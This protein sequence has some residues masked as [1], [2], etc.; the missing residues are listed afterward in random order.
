MTSPLKRSLAVLGVIAL[1]AAGIALTGLPA[2]A[3]P[4]SATIAAPDCAVPAAATVSISVSNAADDAT[5]LTYKIVQD[6]GTVLFDN[7]TLAPGE[8]DDYVI[9]VT[10]DVSTPLQVIDVTGGVIAGAVQTA[11]C[12]PNFSPTAT[13]TIGEA[14]CVLPSGGI[15]PPS[16]GFLWTFDNSSGVGAADYEFVKNDTVVESGTLAAGE[17]RSYAAS[18]TPNESGTSAIR[19]VDAAGDP[20]VVATGSFD[21]DCEPGPAPTGAVTDAS[22]EIPTGGVL[23]PTIPGVEYTFDNSL[24][25]SDAAY[26]FL[27][28]DTVVESGTVA[29]GETRVRSWSLT[30]DLETVVSVTAEDTS[31]EPVVLDSKTVTLDCVANTPTIVAPATD[32]VVTTPTTT[33]SGTGDAGETITI[34]ITPANDDATPVEQADAFAAAAVAV[35]ATLTTT[36]QADGTFS[37]PVEL[38]DGA[39][40]VSASATRA[41]SASGVVPESTSPFSTPTAFSVA[42]AAQPGTT[43]GTGGGTTVSPAGS[44]AGGGNGTLAN[45]GV[46][47]APFAALAAMLLLLGGAVTVLMRRRAA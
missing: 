18:L 16:P 6:Y 22:C 21:L 30:E 20:V 41:A 3:L 14:S 7:V 35:P 31:G 10:E 11:N 47:A 19:S 1:S 23:V 17:T 46:E 38:A 2:Q 24:G 27:D 28:G 43:P 25:T 42:I 37:L 4:S 32:A 15:V 33:I 9:P 13:A 45:T 39:Y 40:L 36:V 5:D 34:V 44:N 29:E 26:A 12:T 8:S